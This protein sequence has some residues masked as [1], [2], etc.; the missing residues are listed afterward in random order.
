MIG[1][2]DECP[3]EKGSQKANGCPDADDDGVPDKYDAC[4]TEPGS[5]ENGGCPKNHAFSSNVV[6]PQETESKLTFNAKNVLFKSSQDIILDE[7]YPSLNNIL[8]I[9]NDYP[10]SRFSINGYTDNTGLDEKNRDLSLRRAQSVMNYFTSKGVA[11]SRLEIKGFGSANPIA[12]N[13]TAEGKKTNR[14]VEI[15]IL[16]K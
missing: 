6:I 10:Q 16:N 7:S 12:T 4:K 14:R 5:A 9:M 2:E 1:K 11:A 8:K 3:Q 15:R 13:E